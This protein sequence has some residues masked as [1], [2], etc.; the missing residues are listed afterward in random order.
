MVEISTTCFG[1]GLEA[2]PSRTL[3]CTLTCCVVG[4]SAL[5]IIQ[6]AFIT[7]QESKYSTAMFPT[8]D[9]MTFYVILTFEGGADG[10]AEQD[11]GVSC[12]TS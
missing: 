8:L 2:S 7:V 11:K 9:N 5:D 12:Y 6:L 10:D 1:S 4:Q 3:K